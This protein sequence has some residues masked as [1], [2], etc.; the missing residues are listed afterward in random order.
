MLAGLATLPP[1]LFPYSHITVGSLS[2]CECSTL[3]LN[4]STIGI[5]SIVD[6]F[7]RCPVGIVLPTVTSLFCISHLVIYPFVNV[8]HLLPLAPLSASF[9]LWFN[10]RVN[11]G[12][13][14]PNVTPLI[15]MP[16]LVSYPLWMP[17]SCFRLFTI[18]LSYVSPMSPWVVLP[19]M[20]VHVIFGFLPFVNALLLLSFIPS[21]ASCSLL[22]KYHCIV[23]LCD[24]FISHVTFGSMTF[25]IALLFC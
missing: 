9:L 5:L 13:V 4:F 25:V 16:H 14:L 10:S 19:S 1:W 7:Q 2:L 20:T 15:G 11:L 21:S 18:V 17:Y 22:F 23:T 24:S 6:S 8:L 12:V 3:A